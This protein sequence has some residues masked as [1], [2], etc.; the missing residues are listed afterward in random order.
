MVLP[1]RGD[2]SG[3]LKDTGTVVDFVERL[4]Q[5]TLMLTDLLLLR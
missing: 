3:A 4:T 2:H 1:A 5:Q